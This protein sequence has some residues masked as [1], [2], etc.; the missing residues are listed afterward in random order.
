MAERSKAQVCGGSLAV[1]VVSSPAAGID[2]LSLVSV[3]CYQV[4]ISAT[5]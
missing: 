1:I 5:G 4:E 3:V 2:I